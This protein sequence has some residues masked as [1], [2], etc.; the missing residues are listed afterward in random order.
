MT[1]TE[2]A[3][4][5]QLTFLRK[6]NLPFVVMLDD[7]SKIFH[8]P[9]KKLN[10]VEGKVKGKP[11]KKRSVLDHGVLAKHV[12][13]HIDKLEVGGIAHVPNIDAPNVMSSSVT[14][15]A[16]QLFGGGNYMTK[17]DPENNVVSV[18]RLA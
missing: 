12:R 7:G 3:I 2:Q 1:L 11:R 17:A 13:T 15:I 4:E 8:D 10:L 18:I 16:N 14:S 9:D 5:K 6:L